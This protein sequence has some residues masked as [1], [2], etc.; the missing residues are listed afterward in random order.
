MNR[1]MLR[2]Y[3]L[4]ILS[5]AVYGCMPLMA[6]I[7]YEDG[8]TPLGLVFLR[9]LVSI[10]M[11]ALAT[12]LCGASLKV[13]PRALPTVGTLATLGCCI[14]PMLLYLSY[15]DIDTGTATVIHFIVP[16]GVMLIGII[17]L[18]H[19]VTLIGCVSIVLSVVGIMFFYTPGTKM[20]LFG[21]MAALLS[22]IVYAIYIV[23]I[24]ISKY[25]D[26]HV[27]T[28]N[29]WGSVFCTVIS[30]F[31]CL[32]SSTLSLPSTLGGFLLCIVFAICSN[33]LAVVMFQSGARIIGGERASIL[34]ALEPIVSVI[35]GIS[36]LGESA[37]PMTLIGSALIIIA[38]VLIAIGDMKKKGREK[39]S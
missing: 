24:S 20:G 9:N 18:K 22:G 4:V 38:G 7:I 14:T 16:A 28:F 21:S 31:V 33:L 25:K 6:H 19:R 29:L 26:I 5:A 2:G 11:L 1:K 8:M 3:I 35:V 39:D 32:F 23:G 13:A 17:F 37:S 27:F 36:F 12:R 10:P 30:F 34:C 15:S